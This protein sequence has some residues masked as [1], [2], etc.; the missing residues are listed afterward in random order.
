[1]AQLQEDEEMQVDEVPVKQEQE[2][3]EPSDDQP[4]DGPAEKITRIEGNIE[5]EDGGD[6]EGGGEVEVEVAVELEVEVAVEP[7]PEVE[8]GQPS[9]NNAF[10]IVPP[11]PPPPP[12]PIDPLNNPGSGLKLIPAP[13]LAPAPALNPTPTLVLVT[14]LA[15]DIIVPNDDD[16]DVA[17]DG[18]EPELKSSNGES[19][20]EFA[21][22]FACG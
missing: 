2:E 11:P 5:G 8:G 12:P 16:T 14:E 20:C 19:I 10:L 17:V 21:F 7:E 1:M 13:A 6:G 22:A 9:Y 4:A 3:D 15:V 18:L